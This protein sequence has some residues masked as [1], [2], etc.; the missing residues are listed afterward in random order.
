M[1]RIL[2][3][4][5]HPTP[6]HPPPREILFAFW[7][8]FI[9]QEEQSQHRSAHGLIFA[10]VHVASM[11]P[12][13]RFLFMMLK[14]GLPSTTW[15]SRPQIPEPTPSDLPSPGMLCYLNLSNSISNW[16]PKVYMFETIGSTSHSNDHEIGRGAPGSGT[17]LQVPAWSSCFGFPQI[18]LSSR[19]AFSHNILYHSNQEESVSYQDGP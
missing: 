4:P 14:S 19:A 13:V 16:G 18:N 12:A 5:S 3:P 17:H 11:Q 15:K 10:D 2:L 8:T 7:I 9:S 1:L 6:P